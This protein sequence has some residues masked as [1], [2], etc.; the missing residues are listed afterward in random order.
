QDDHLILSVRDNGVGFAPGEVGAS[1][2]QGLRNIEPRAGEMGG[3]L[4]VESAP[5]R[6]TEVTVTIPVVR[7][8]EGTW[9]GADKGLDR[10]RS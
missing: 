4:F 8:K 7:G 3:R 9:D 6:G 10:R 2:G 5:G 1:A